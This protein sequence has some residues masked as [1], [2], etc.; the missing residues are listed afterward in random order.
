MAILSLEF[1]ISKFRLTNSDADIK[2]PKQFN[3][4]S[5]VTGKLLNRRSVSKKF[6]ALTFQRLAYPYLA[7]S[8]WI[9]F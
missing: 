2:S 1:V 7:K 5:N 4:H 6:R 9:G 8:N 3:L